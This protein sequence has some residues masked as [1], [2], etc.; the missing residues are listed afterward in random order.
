[1]IY[2]KRIVL[3]NILKKILR[4][5][6]IINFFDDFLYFSSTLF[7]VESVKHKNVFIIFFIY[8]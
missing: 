4:E 8:K 2:M 6:K 7:L 1:M 5:K 3:G